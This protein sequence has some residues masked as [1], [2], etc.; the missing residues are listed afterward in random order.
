MANFTTEERELFEYRSKGVPL[1]VCAERMNISTSTAKRLSR[2]VNAKIIR[3][4]PYNV[5]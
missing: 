3:L 4:C 2:R 1:E 5:I